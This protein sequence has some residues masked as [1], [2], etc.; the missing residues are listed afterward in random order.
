MSVA[1]AP[2]SNLGDDVLLTAAYAGDAQAFEELF[3]RHYPRVYGVIMRIVGNAED[4]EEIALDVFL[5]LH[6]QRLPAGDGVNVA[7]WLYKTA[8]NA[9]FN[10][11]RSRK[12]RLRW[13]DRFMQLGR[14]DAHTGTDPLEIVERRD[15]ADR[16]REALARL[17]EKQRDALVLKASG[18]TYGEIADAIGV[19]PSSVGT[20]LVRGERRL[21]GEM[22]GGSEQ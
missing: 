2:V 8:T 15:D 4:A 9:S 7:G 3:T 6:E 17:P 5:R 18:L 20:I 21:R 11:V 10:A 1:S 12:R 13:L 16:V 22:R 19:K 14:R